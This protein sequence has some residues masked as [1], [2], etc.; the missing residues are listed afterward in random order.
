MQH[1]F[2]APE[3]LFGLNMNFM[4]LNNL[5]QL[6]QVRSIH[7]A[8]G[9]SLLPVQ[10]GDCCA[11][12]KPGPANLKAKLYKSLRWLQLVRCKLQ[13]ETM[14]RHHLK[15]GYPMYTND[16]VPPQKMTLVW[17]GLIMVTYTKP[18]KGSNIERNSMKFIAVALR[19][20]SNFK[21]PTAKAISWSSRTLAGA[22]RKTSWIHFFGGARSRMTSHWFNT[23]NLKIFNKLAQ[24][25]SKLKF[26]CGNSEVLISCSLK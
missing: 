25:M 11:L 4:N 8:L 2:A 24:N 6:F 7:I 21:D 16:Y 14:L 18:A 26:A 23:A 10:L 22:H 20:W 12:Q 15:V 17:Y 13:R 3:H 19:I 9:W 5:L 1:Q